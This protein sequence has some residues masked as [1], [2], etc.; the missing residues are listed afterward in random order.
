MSIIVTDKGFEKDNWTD[1]FQA[2]DDTNVL[3]Q[4]REMMTKGLRGI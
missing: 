3:D 4:D 1:G 2:W